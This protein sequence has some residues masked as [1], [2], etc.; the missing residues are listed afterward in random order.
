M[1][2]LPFYDRDISKT[3]ANTMNGSFSFGDRVVIS[4]QAKDLVESL[5]KNDP[6]QRISL[7]RALEHDWFQIL[8]YPH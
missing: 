8:A 2:T 7:D 3:L 1:G 4:P 5:L 6:T